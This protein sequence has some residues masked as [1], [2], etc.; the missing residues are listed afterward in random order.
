DEFV[1]S[2]YGMNEDV[3]KNKVKLIQQKV[4]E[5]KFKFDNTAI[6]VEL[7]QGGITYPNVEAK[8]I[9]ELISIADKN[10]YKAKE[11]G[12]NNAVIGQDI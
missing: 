1:V 12:R 7:S 3:L 11:K 2:F 4:K 9:D 10:L 8:T 6:K 5:F